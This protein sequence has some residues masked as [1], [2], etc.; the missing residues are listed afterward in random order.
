MQHV[1]LKDSDPKGGLISI[2]QPVIDSRMGMWLNFS[3][4]DNKEMAAENF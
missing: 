3:Q 2:S 1:E 4:L